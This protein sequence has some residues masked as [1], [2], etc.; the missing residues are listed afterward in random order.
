DAGIT[1]LD[2]ILETNAKVHRVADLI[3]S[4]ATMGKCRWVLAVP[5]AS[6]VQSVKD[7]NGKAIATEVVNLTRRYLRSHGVRARVEFSWGPTEN[8]APE[9]VDAIVDITETGG[10]L[11]ANGLRIVDTVLETWTQLIANRAAWKDP[12]KREKIESL[13]LLMQA[14]IAAEGRVGLK[15][16]V[17]VKDLD[18]VVRILPAITSPTISH[19][20]DERWVAV[21]TI[22]AE[23]TVRKTLPALR[24][25]GAV[26]IVEYPL[27]KVIE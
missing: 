24:K 13:A 27:N 21:E 23:T 10:S 9:F 12:W 7:L 16:N 1:G 5:N 3:Y 14:A 4:K 2:W 26:G 19:L 25:A 11:R 8:K 15:L 17:Q 22:I 20:K 6:P 18:K